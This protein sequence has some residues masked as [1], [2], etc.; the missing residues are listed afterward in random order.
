MA[1]MNI[2]TKYITGTKD[3][4]I[5][6]KTFTTVLHSFMIDAGKQAVRGADAPNCKIH[7]LK[8]PSKELKI[9]DFQKKDRLLVLNFGSST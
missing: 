7:S 3:L 9:L 4:K 5:T 8:E 6:F 1:I 2:Y